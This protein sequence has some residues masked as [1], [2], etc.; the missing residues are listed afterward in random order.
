MNKITASLGF[1]EI[2]QCPTA[3]NDNYNLRRDLGELLD[4]LKGDNN[5]KERLA[6]LLQM[7]STIITHE[8]TQHLRKV[9][10]ESILPLI[11][12]INIWRE[13]MIGYRAA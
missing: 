8:M 12:R 7:V 6:K 11:V 1:G 13:I 3:I 4:F 2:I 5:D 9:Y 10:G